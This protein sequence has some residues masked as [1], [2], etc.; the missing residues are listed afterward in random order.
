MQHTIINLFA[1]VS[2]SCEN[3]SAIK[4]MKTFQDVK[5]AIITITQSL[6]GPEH[7]T[8]EFLMPLKLENINSCH[9]KSLICL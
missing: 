2:T 1:Q 4:L 3:N 7:I 5:L 9:A 8:Q 6:K